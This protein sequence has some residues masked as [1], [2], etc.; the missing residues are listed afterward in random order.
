M[1]LSY[2]RDASLVVAVRTSLR[3]VQLEHYVKRQLA[4]TRVAW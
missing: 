4:A 3:L 2:L 1:T